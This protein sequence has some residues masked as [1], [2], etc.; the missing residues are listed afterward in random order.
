LPLAYWLG[1]L[2]VCQP[3]AGFV[4]TTG[5]LAE[6]R[7]QRRRRH[8]FF[9]VLPEQLLDVGEQ[10]DPDRAFVEVLGEGERRI[11]R[12][13]RP[14]AA[15]NIGDREQGLPVVLRASL[16]ASGSAG[17][18]C[19]SVSTLSSA[20]RFACRRSIRNC[21]ASSTLSFVTFS[22]GLRRFIGRMIARSRSVAAS[23]PIEASAFGAQVENSFGW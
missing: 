11:A 1:S 15:G 2:A 22:S 14:A 21:G 23:L 18:F 5:K 9:L 17:R 13:R 8:A 20:Q 10:Q 7:R 3:R 4:V 16:S 19:F 12:Q 6:P